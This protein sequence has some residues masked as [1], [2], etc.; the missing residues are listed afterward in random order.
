MLGHHKLPVLLAAL[1]EVLNRWQRS[2]QPRVVPA[3]AWAG[4]GQGRGGQRGP[5]HHRHLHR[6]DQIQG[7]EEEAQVLLPGS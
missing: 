4:H 3:A 7:Q 5:A 2:Q 6:Q 1:P